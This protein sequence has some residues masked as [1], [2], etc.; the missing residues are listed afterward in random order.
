MTYDDLTAWL[1]EYLGDLLAVA[2]QDIG[3]DVALDS[4]GVDSATAL[5][6]SVDLSEETGHPTRPVEIFEHPSIAELA[7]YLT[8]P[9]TAAA[10]GVR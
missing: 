6:L 7:R 1:Q 8:R 10:G 3:V 9:R 4:L 2:P 5:V